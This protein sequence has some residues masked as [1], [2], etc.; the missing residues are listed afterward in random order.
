MEH[1]HYCDA[2]AFLSIVKNKELW[3]SDLRNV[4]DPHELK[5]APS[6]IKQNFHD[7][8][9]TSR[10]S[11][12]EGLAVKDNAFFSLSLSKTPDLLSQWRAYSRNGTG[13]QIG[14]DIDALKACN[15][16]QR[17][18]IPINYNGASGVPIIDVGEVIYDETAFSAFIL[19]KLKT[20]RQDHQVPFEKVG[21]GAKLSDVFLINDLV[22]N[23]CLL[24]SDFYAEE[25]E[26]RVFLSVNYRRMEEFE[27]YRSTSLKDVIPN[28]RVSGSV[29]IPYIAIRV[30]NP[31]YNLQAVR[32]VTLGPNNNSRVEDVDRFLKINGYK[33]VEVR[34]SE[35]VLR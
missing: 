12:P 28:F 34:N 13:F 4:N 35:G 29:L 26:V 19:E 27:F 6:I 25:K 32:S 2:D 18:G 8:F 10:Y 15:F 9:P 30:F 23:L 33:D 11:F 21:E 24:K 22:K 7:I 3:L 14:I 1:Y 31:E 5:A 20:F 17:S 16:G